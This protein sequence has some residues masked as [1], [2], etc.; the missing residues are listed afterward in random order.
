MVPIFFLGFVISITSGLRGPHHPRG[1]ISSHHHYSPQK[2]IKLTQDAELLHDTTHLQEDLGPIAEQL[3]LSKMSERELEFHY[4]K[5]HDVDNNTKLDGLEILHAIQH[6]LHEYNGDTADTMN[7]GDYYKNSIPNRPNDEEDVMNWIIEIIDK[8]MEED[9]VNN[10]GYLEYI[11][12]VMGKQRA[13]NE[14]ERLK[15]EQ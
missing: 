2:E 1:S 9:D 15:L 13:Q 3:D 7:H 14:N 5:V 10:D 8:V 6:S 4:F 11:E 12:Y